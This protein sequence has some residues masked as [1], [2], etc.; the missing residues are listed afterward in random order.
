MK[1]IGTD[2]FRLVIYIV[3]GHGVDSS[4]DEGAPGGN[5]G[6]ICLRCFRGI[7]AKNF[8]FHTSP[9]ASWFHRPEAA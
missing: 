2:V 9:T 8:P 3:F 7:I 6:V 1:R 4:P 5:R